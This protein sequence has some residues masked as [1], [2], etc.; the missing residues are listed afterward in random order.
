MG[1]VDVIQMDADS[2]DSK[3]TMETK[4]KIKRFNG[5][6][7][8]NRVDKLED[9]IETIWEDV[10]RIEEKLVRFGFME[11]EMNGSNGSNG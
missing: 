1:I 10:L 6:S 3:E 11:N 9:Q 2:K 7:L 8:E 5:L 4:G